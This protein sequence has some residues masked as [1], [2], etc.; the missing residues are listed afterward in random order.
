MKTKEKAKK[1]YIIPIEY[2]KDQ[3]LQFTKEAKA[4]RKSLSAHLNYLTATHP[5]HGDEIVA[6]KRA[7]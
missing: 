5:V 2:T 1:R 7:S 3:Y 4:L 6:M